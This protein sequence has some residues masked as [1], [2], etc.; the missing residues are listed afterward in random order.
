MKSIKKFGDGLKDFL[1]SLTQRRSASNRNS[2]VRDYLDREELRAI[3]KSGTANKIFRIKTSSALS[4]TI[5]FQSKEDELIYKAKIEKAVKKACMFQLGFGRGIVVIH[6]YGASLDQPLK[7]GWNRNKYKLD[8]FSGDMVTAI[9][10]SRDLAD[11]RYYKP[12][13]YVVRGASIHWTRVADFSYVEPVQEEAPQYQYGGISESELIY[14]Q[15]VNDGI[16][17][18]A[19]ASIV[20]KNSSFFYKVKD[21]KSLMMQGKEENLIKYISAMEDNRSIYGAG[22]I[23]MDDEVQSIAQALTNLKEVDDVSLRRLSLVTSIPVSFLVGENVKGLNSSGD[24]EQKIYN[25]AIQAYQE[26]Y[27]VDTLNELLMKLGLEPITFKDE[28]GTT[29]LETANYE[30]VIIGNAVLLRDMGEDQNSYLIEKG[31][32][33]K[34]TAENFFDED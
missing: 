25:D 18:R 33:K 2:F 6:E 26:F 24:N 23:D 5:Q 13:F 14:D 27:I 3:Y 17:E 32:T 4:K 30:K 1:S 15:L 29:P 9:E 20:E 31:L 8:V 19:S 10:A 28:Q 22:I 7:D 21:F 12:K 34:E 11:E 16:I